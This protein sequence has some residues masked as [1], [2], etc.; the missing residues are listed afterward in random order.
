MLI[1]QTG[2]LP[3]PPSFLQKLRPTPNLVKDITYWNPVCGSSEICSWTDRKP[4]RGE[5]VLLQIK[6]IE[7]KPLPYILACLP[8]VPEDC[9]VY[10]LVELKK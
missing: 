1:L 3:P 8:V 5:K 6:R 7:R 9:S 2:F 4:V 10:V